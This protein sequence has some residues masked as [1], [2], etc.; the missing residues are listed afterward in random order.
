MLKR[1][2]ELILEPRGILNARRQ[3]AVS[4]IYA[5]VF[6]SIMLVQKQNIF[7]TK[8]VCLMVQNLF[9]MTNDNVPF[10]FLPMRQNF[11]FNLMHIYANPES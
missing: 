1:R 10:D 2:N 3:A 4:C 5:S 9:L 6:K 8:S 7:F 11:I